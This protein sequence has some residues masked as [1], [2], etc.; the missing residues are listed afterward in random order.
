MISVRSASNKHI[1]TNFRHIST[2][3]ADVAPMHFFKLFKKK[4]KH[5]LSD[6]FCF[7]HHWNKYILVTLVQKPWQEPKRQKWQVQRQT[8]TD[9]VLTDTLDFGK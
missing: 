1:K 5:Y 7:K 2:H 8:C 4:P 9:S 6:Y 3:L